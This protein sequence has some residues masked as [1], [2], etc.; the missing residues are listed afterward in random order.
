MFALFI[1]ANAAGGSTVY[2]WGSENLCKDGVAPYG[3]TYW[4]LPRDQFSDR[5]VITVSFLYKVSD[6]MKNGTPHLHAHIISDN[7]Y[8]PMD[9]VAVI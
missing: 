8:A 6:A 5:D 7:V 9:P 1:F 3:D 2:K 4:N